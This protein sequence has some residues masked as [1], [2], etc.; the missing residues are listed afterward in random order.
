ML[1]TDEE[2][3]EERLRRQDVQQ[4]THP[5]SPRCNDERLNLRGRQGGR[6]VMSRNK[7]SVVL[8]QSVRLHVMHIF[9]DSSVPPQPASSRAALK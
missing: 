4:V 1:R 6:D 9:G 3:W 8:L 5:Y 2:Q 7:T